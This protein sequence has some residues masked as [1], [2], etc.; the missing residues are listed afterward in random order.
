[1]QVGQPPWLAAGLVVHADADVPGPGRR[2]LDP[3]PKAT[4]WPERG[5]PHEL[6]G[7]AEGHRLGLERPAKVAMPR[8]VVL[9]VLVAERDVEQGLLASVE[10]GTVR[11]L[12]LGEPEPP[13]APLRVRLDGAQLQDVVGDDAH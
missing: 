4:A 7:D 8:R 12:A 10:P 3:S 13:H 2:V 1:M 5:L 11:P 6:D 9:L